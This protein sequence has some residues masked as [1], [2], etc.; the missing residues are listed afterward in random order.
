MRSERFMLFFPV[1]SV[2]GLMRK[3]NRH[4][5]KHKKNAKCKKH[6]KKKRLLGKERGTACRHKKRK[7]YAS[8]LFVFVVTGNNKQNRRT[9]TQYRNLQNS[10]HGHKPQSNRKFCVPMHTKHDYTFLLHKSQYPFLAFLTKILCLS[11]KQAK[12]AKKS[13]LRKANF[14]QNFAFR[15]N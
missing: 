14:S 8:S 1:F 13:R 2:H 11:L 9:K 4:K 5:R 7:Q 3:K 12:I 6:G 10:N 15:Q